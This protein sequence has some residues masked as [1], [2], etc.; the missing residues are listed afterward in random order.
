MI[1]C[2]V[3]K[4]RDKL[5]TFSDRTFQKCCEAIQFRKSRALKY[6]DLILTVENRDKYGYHCDCYKK[7]T[8]L[9]R[10]YSDVSDVA[11]TTN[12]VSLF[13]NLYLIYKVR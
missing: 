6:G 3:C 12:E 10:Q 5:K 8:A 9:K 4:R 13:R 7:I 1:V 2:I 11:V